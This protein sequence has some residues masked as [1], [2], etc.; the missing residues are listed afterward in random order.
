MINLIPPSAK[1]RIIKEYWLRVAAVWLFLLSG[2]FAL[3]A[4]TMTP[5]FVLVNSQLSALTLANSVP[6]EDIQ[7][8]QSVKEDVERANQNAR[9]LLTDPVVLEGNTIVTTLESLG[10]AQVTLVGFSI[11]RSRTVISNVSVRGVARNRS[12]LVDFQEAVRAHEIF[13]DA[14]LPLSSFAESEDISFTMK[15]MINDQI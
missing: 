8:F 9:T 11:A 3:I 10:S 4:L 15:V 14:E 6:L 2:A 7:T 5:L 12:A 1:K 13:S